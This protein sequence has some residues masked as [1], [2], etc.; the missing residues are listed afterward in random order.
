MLGDHGLYG[1]SVP[2]E[3]SLRVP[4]IVAG[5]GIEGGRVS[6]EPV[7]LIDTNATICEWAGLPPQ[8]NI[9]AQSLGP[10]LRG[11]T[12]DHRTESISQIGRFRL[13]RTKT[14]K[15]IENQND[16]NELYDLEN[17]PDELNN[18]ANENSDIAKK[19]S[20]RLEERF[21]EGTWLRG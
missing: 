2:Y 20:H 11:E 9:D 8:E 1:K 12:N 3:A 18:I 7:E 19:L 17:D 6:A 13:I 21:K 15:L 10:V 14:H 16:I 4:L 5:P